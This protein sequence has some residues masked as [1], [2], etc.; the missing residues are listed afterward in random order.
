[1]IPHEAKAAKGGEDAFFVSPARGGAFGVADG[2]GG[3]ASEG[4]DVAAYSRAICAAVKDSIAAQGT[5]KL[6]LTCWLVMDE[7]LAIVVGDRRGRMH[8][9]C[10]AP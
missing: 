5:S 2:V 9:T 4:V 8:S 6:D 3:W 10:V 1:M 7:A